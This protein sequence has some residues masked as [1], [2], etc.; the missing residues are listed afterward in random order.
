MCAAWGIPCG[1]T[2]KTFAGETMPEMFEPVFVS[3]V[4]HTTINPDCPFCPKNEES[5]TT[6]GGVKND[7]GIL[8]DVM[9]KP[10]T[11]VEKQG[12]ARPK[13]GNPKR[14]LPD[15]ASPK[16]NPI[17]THATYG[18][19]SCEAHHIIPG[20][21]SLKGSAIEVWIESTHGQIKSDTGYSVNN[22]A[23]GRWMPSIPEK[24]RNGTW[25]AMDFDKKLEIATL[26][27]QSKGQF[28]KGHHNIGDPDDPAGTYHQR[29]CDQIKGQLNDLAKTVTGWSSA[30]FESTASGPPFDPNWKI[31]GMLDR[32]SMA[33]AGNITST[34][35]ATWR[36]YISR[37]ALER[38]KRSGC[39]CNL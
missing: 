27:M 3:A 10:A 18:D 35:P 19:Y 30:C 31:H 16:P 38:H 37:L 11:L 5:F 1:T 12:G 39:N 8:A 34:S 33:I 23:N 28:H 20:N 14:Q 26:A 7:S 24:Y 25:G 4:K 9:A 17:F 29:Y 6:H 21:Q 2:R 13:D 22:A 36:Y 15:T 32:I